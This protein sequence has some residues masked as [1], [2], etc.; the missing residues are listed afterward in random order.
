M[1]VGQDTVIDVVHARMISVSHELSLS[2]NPTETYYLYIK[3]RILKNALR[4]LKKGVGFVG[5]L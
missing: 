2:D 1:D 4:E 3:M 5:K